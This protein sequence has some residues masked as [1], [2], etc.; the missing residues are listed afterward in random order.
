MPD[1]IGRSVGK[2]LFTLN[3][4]L[5]KQKHKPTKTNQKCFN[6]LPLSKLPQAFL[7]IYQGQTPPF[8]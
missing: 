4:D 5:D 7:V 8:Y 6:P 1:L 3:N 2:L